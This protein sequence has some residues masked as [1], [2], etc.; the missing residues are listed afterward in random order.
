MTR[1]VTELHETLMSE[2]LQQSISHTLFD[3]ASTFVE[4]IGKCVTKPVLGPLT[5]AQ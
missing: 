5:C 1:V 3:L 2:K 4:V